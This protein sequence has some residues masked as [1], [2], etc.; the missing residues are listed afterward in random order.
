M[1]EFI[2]LENMKNISVLVL[3]HHLQNHSFFS[4]HWDTNAI[5]YIHLHTFKHTHTFNFYSL[6]VCGG[7]L[8]CVTLLYPWKWSNDIVLIILELDY[9]LISNWTSNLSL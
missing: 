6:G 3:P 9:A 1:W 8:S 4:H 5:I 7:T 2:L